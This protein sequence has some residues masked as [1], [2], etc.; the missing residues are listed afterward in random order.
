ME[1]AL[2]KETMAYV[3]KDTGLK[4]DQVVSMDISELNK[5]IE[6]KD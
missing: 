1:F 2:S 4:Y 5:V 3:E 6:K